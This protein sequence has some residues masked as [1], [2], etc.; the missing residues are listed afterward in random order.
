MQAQRIR[1]SVLR[2]VAVGMVAVGFLLGSGLVEGDVQTAY[3]ASPCC[4]RPF[5][6]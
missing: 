2:L 4:G 5:D 6:R 3:A 1:H